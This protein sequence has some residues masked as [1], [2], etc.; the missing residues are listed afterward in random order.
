M[1]SNQLK[2]WEI[3]EAKRANKARE[4]ETARSNLANESTRLRTQLE[5]ARHNR[6]SEAE[7]HRSNVARETETARANRQ[8]ELLTAVRNAETQRS[9]LASERLKSESNK[10]SAAGVDA[11]RYSA[12]QRLASSKYAANVNKNIAQA[13]LTETHRANKQRELIGYLGEA[14]K[15]INTVGN[16]G[17]KLLGGR[18][19]GKV[20]TRQLIENA[21]NPKKQPSY[22]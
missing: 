9:N 8:N 21:T 1:T 18:S 2:Y 10:I 5:D 17:T 19:N 22:W 7:T 12:D 14:N 11:T 6:A 20:S 13:Q 15:L 4:T 3:S 16:V